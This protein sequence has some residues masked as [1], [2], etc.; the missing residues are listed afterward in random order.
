MRPIADIEVYKR[1]PIE[2]RIEIWNAFPDYYMMKAID[3]T[4]YDK[5]YLEDNI[6]YRLSKFHETYIISDIE[7]ATIQSDFISQILKP[8]KWLD[9]YP[10]KFL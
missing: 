10:E 5:G 7:L 6:R 9:R 4:K 2:A 8:N 3:G 1:L